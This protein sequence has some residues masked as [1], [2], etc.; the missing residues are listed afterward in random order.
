MNGKGDIEVLSTSYEQYKAWDEDQKDW[1]RWNILQSLVRTCHSRQ[2]GC[3][4]RYVKKWHIISTF[5]FIAGLV[6]G[7]GFLEFKV[8][9]PAV[10]K[11]LKSIFKI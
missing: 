8:I 5:I 2:T 11:L 9:L 6:A 3:D 1:F 4:K 10:L 7:Y